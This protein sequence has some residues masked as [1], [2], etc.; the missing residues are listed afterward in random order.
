MIEKENNKLSPIVNNCNNE[1]FREELKNLLPLI[2]E[3][4]I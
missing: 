4:K 2:F 3:T 1:K